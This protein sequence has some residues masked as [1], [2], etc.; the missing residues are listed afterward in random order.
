MIVESG[1][2]GTSRS[3]E[4]G[5]MSPIMRIRQWSRLSLTGLHGLRRSSRCRKRSNRIGY[6]QRSSRLA[7]TRRLEVIMTSLTTVSAGQPRAIGLPASENASLDAN[8]VRAWKTGKLS[9]GSRLNLGRTDREQGFTVREDGVFPLE[10]TRSGVQRCADGS[11]RLATA[12]A[13]GAIRPNAAGHTY[14]RG[15]END[16]CG[17][18]GPED[19]HMALATGKPA[20]V[21]SS[22]G[23]FAVEK[24]ADGFLVRQLAGKPSSPVEQGE[25]DRAITS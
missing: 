15:R 1:R 11:E 4:R 12:F 20:Y 8:V 24:E 18:P 3:R 14:P 6:C 25:L 9:D 22:R 5:P 23:A 7:E 17:L 10:I 19:G 16:V 13:L 2:R 21:L